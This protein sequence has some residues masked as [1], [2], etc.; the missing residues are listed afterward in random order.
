[1]PLVSASDR[2]VQLIGRLRR[3]AAYHKREMY[4]HRKELRQ[5]MAELAAAEADRQGRGT[6]EG[7]IHGPG[8]Q[9]GTT[10]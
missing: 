2:L 9:P 3:E 4:R 10:A 8:P 5:V 6:H 7:V 1:M